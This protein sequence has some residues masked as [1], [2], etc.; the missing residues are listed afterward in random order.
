MLFRSA[1]WAFI[2]VWCVVGSS[3]N[4]AW[5]EDA[6]QKITFDDHV[7]PIFREHCLTCHNANDKKSDLALDTYANT[8]RGGASG[9]VVLAGD[10]DSSRLYG[11]TSHTEEPKMPPEQDRIA[12]AKLEL[13]RK[14]IEGGA[15]ENSGSVA[16]SV[17]KPA[18]EVTVTANSANKPA[19]EPAMPAGLLRQPVVHTA[20]PGAI[21]A[22]AASPWAPLIAVAG[23]KQILLYHSEN[24]QLLGVLPFAEGVPHVLKFSRNGSLLLAGG[25]RAA[26][27]GKVVVFDV[28]TGKRVTEVGDEL[29]V[30]LA[31]DINNTH[32]QIAL[33]G[34]GKIV[35]VYA[36]ADGSLQYELTKHT[37]W[38]YA[39]EFSPDGILLATADRS[40]GLFVWEA[41]TGREYQSFQTHK[42]S[43]TDV[44]WRGD[45][46]VLASASLDGTVKLWEMEN[47]KEIKSIPAHGG[48]V[49]AIAFAAD[50]KLVSTGRDRLT[51]TWQNDAAATALKSCEGLADFGLETAFTHDGTRVVGGD[52]TGK[53]CVWNVEDGKLLFELSANPPTLQMRVAQAAAAL[54]AAEAA[55][56][57]ARAERDQAQT[58]LAAVN[59][60]DPAGKE[61]AEAALAAKAAALQAAEL[62]LAS[63]QGVHSAAVAEEQAFTAAQ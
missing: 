9:E 28:A 44:R 54:Q 2:S 38:V 6:P 8:M 7:R 17:N 3:A 56:N 15:L 26:S 49:E 41:D 60:E 52:V 18:V 48:G 42:G 31:A 33:A 59:S 11:L 58:Q 53:V 37:D 51:K 24:G 34:P 40:N 62:A 1:T 30:V 55:T 27:L 10:I 36:V 20:R 46:N 50:G 12:D 29:D 13:I 61:A 14:W 19:G 5:A 32:S 16:K 23:Q 21:T 39:L 47:G 22:L 63:A 57:M 45:S 25:G 4:F 43:V 35:R